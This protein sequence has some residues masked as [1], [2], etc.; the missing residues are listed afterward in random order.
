MALTKPYVRA[1]NTELDTDVAVATD[2]GDGNEFVAIR[3]QRGLV[4]SESIGRK[5]QQEADH[6]QRAGAQDAAYR[7]TV[8]SYRSYRMHY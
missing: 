3:R 1:G 8:L 5:N 2:V 4:V 7:D 6:R